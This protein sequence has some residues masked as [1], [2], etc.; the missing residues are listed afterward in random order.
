[1]VYC[2][3]HLVLANFF[4]NHEVNSQPILFPCLLGASFLST[5]S[6][7]QHQHLWH[8]GFPHI[9]C[10]EGITGPGE[11]LEY[12][13]FFMAR[14]TTPRF[15]SLEAKSIYLKTS[16][17]RWG[18]DKMLSGSRQWGIS[19]PPLGTGL[20]STPGIILSLRK[21]RLPLWDSRGNLDRRFTTAKPWK[22]FKS[23]LI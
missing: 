12:L 1:M 5:V 11:A 18:K 6:L 9:R 10:S 3:H 14:L 8:L 15:S 19:L 23:R 17:V 21:A 22:E 7:F 16:T 13:F 20:P 2:I 4:L